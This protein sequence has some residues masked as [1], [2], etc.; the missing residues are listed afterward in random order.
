MADSSFD[1]V[2]KVDQQEVANAVN[3][4]AKEISQRYDFKNVGASVVLSGE[5]IRMT[6]NSEERANHER[7]R[8]GR[9]RRQALRAGSLAIERYVWCAARRRRRTRDVAA[10]ATTSQVRTVRLNKG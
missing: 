9:E 4:A 3:Q 1:I 5:T 7:R 8:D 2:S 10:S 6:A